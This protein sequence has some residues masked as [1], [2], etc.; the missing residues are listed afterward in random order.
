MYI[1][2]PTMRVVIDND[3][4]HRRGARTCAC[5]V[6]QP[7]PDATTTNGPR[8]DS[9]VRGNGAHGGIRAS[10]LGSANARLT[11]LALGW[12]AAHGN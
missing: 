12:V 5:K 11:D 7:Q 2:V 8:K 10:G 6:A 9:V 3:R 4:A 1:R